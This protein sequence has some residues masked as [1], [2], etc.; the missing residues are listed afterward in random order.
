MPH[1]VLTGAITIRRAAEAFAPFLLREGDRVIKAERLYTESG[2]RAALI[3]MIVS[4]RGFTQKFFIQLAP[5]DGGMTVRL[6]PLTDP[7]KTPAV[8]RAIG[9][10]ARRLRDATGCAYGATN[11]GEYLTG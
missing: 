2:E 9:E 4:E 3:E 8:R 10:V 1:V 5:R 6:E 11:I 7:E